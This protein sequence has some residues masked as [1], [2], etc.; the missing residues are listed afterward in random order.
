MVPMNSYFFD[1]DQQGIAEAVAATDGDCLPAPP[2]VF[3]SAVMV[4]DKLLLYGGA[5]A[6]ASSHFLPTR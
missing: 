5:L 6:P 1:S 2:L 3:H 4:D